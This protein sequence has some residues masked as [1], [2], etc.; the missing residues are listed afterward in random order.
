L[1]KRTVSLLA[2][3]ALVVP[4]AAAAKTIEVS[5]PATIV[6]HG[7]VRGQLRSAEGQARVELHLSGKILVTGRARDLEVSCTGE[8]V[9]TRSHLNRRGLELVACK[10]RRMTV[11]VSAS[12][13]RFGVLARRWLIQIPEG[14]TG[15]LHGRFRRQD[16]SSSE[17]LAKPAEPEEAPVRQ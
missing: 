2:L 4:A 3:A 10:G 1:L 8:N 11:V 16:D 14:V 6:G 9:Q 5:G 15:K 12:A 13:F 7:P 17:R